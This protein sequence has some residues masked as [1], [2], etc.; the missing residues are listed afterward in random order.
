MTT[1]FDIKD[2]FSQKKYQLIIA[3]DA[4]PFSHIKT[5]GQVLTQ[6][7]A[8]GVSVALEPIARAANGI[9][10]ARGRTQE[11]KEASGK[12]GIIQ[13]T[14]GT[15]SYLLKRLFFSPEEIDGYYY[16]FAN[17]TLWPLS[18]IAFEQPVFAPL[19]FG[20]YQKVNEVY[21]Q[22][23][24]K[25]L[26]KPSFIFL[27][28]YQLALVPQFLPQKPNS[29]IG[30]FWHIPWPTWEIFRILPQKKEIL[31]SLLKVDFIAF[32]RKYQADNFVATVSRELP[33]RV[34]QE[35][36]TIYYNNHAT[37]VQSLPMGI[38]ADVIEDLV[39]HKPSN[40]IS[41][42]VQN[43]LGLTPKELPL[44]EIFD[45]QKVLLGV[46]RL[47]YTK[48]IPLRLLALEEFFTTNP[49]FIG[50][51][52]YVGFLASSREHIQSYKQLKKE[53]DSLAAAINNKFQTDTWVPIRLLPGIFSRDQLVELYRKAAV[54]LVTPLDDGMN[55]VSK[56]FIIAAS[57]TD[58]PGMLILSQFAG[59]ATDLGASLIVN[60]YNT[61]EV[62]LAIK[63][64]LATSAKERKQKITSMSETLKERNVYEWAL[65]FVKHTEQAARENRETS[66]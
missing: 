40:I 64:A 4:Q 11:D 8:G 29:I 38:D 13:V 30:F 27:N 16:G 28:D 61:N 6:T 5:H 56:E 20:Q 15:D 46:D 65:Q 25:Y 12:D 63:N 9:F 31:E 54:C 62:A 48:G 58:N 52:T 66:F 26:D 55:L 59:S 36:G 17:Q 19:W 35:K 44:Q 57:T 39:V 42:Y 50:K 43:L 14:R 22:T 37:V 21:A 47:D 2:F 33:V 45:S 24:A 18:H 7:P 41:S 10:I 49:Q 51:V 23:I 3:S 32:H 60:P 34:D 1:Y 53:V